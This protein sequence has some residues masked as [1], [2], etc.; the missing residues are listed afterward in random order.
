MILYLAIMKIGWKLLLMSS[1][2]LSFFCIK[3][4]VVNT[5][6]GSDDFSQHVDVYACQH[7][8]QNTHNANMH[9]ALW[10]IFDMYD[11]YWR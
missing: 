9:E 5:C 1:M 3:L 11:I 4:E 7:N 2:L 8:I 6:Q 10:H